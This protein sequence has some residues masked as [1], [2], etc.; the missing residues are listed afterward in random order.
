M[1]NEKFAESYY[2]TNN[3]GSYLDR[4]DRYKKTAEELHDKLFKVTS[5]VSKESKIL[6]YGCATGF[7]VKG[8][9]DIGYKNVSGYDISDWAISYGKINFPT[10]R[11]K[12]S[13]NDSVLIG[14]KFDMIISLDVFEHMSLPELDNFLI[15]CNS[16]YVLV[17][18]PLAVKDGGKYVLNISE[19]DPTHK[20]RFTRDSWIKQFSCFGYRYFFSINLSYIYDSPGVLC[21]I[22]KRM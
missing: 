14:T 2:T 8:F 18:I 7:L 10:I 13:S 17:R 11:D 19:Q 21:A 1:S 4:A 6:D 15:N 20:I 5:I 12:I 22:F 3:Y 16:E 9:T